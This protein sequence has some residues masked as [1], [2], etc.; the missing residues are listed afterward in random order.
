[1][2]ALANNPITTARLPHDTRAKLL[3]LSKIKSK[4]MSEII[5][6]SVELY[7]EREENEIDSFTLGEPFFGIYGSGENDRATSYKKR[8]KEKLNAKLNSD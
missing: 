2:K 6:E 8:I 3:A 1:M 4:T 7:Y 5:K